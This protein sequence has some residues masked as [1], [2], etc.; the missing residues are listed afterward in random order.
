MFNKRI[1]LLT[2]TLAIVVISIYL[3]N[4]YKHK[5]KELTANESVSAKKYSPL[6]EN[7]KGEAVV[8]P[9]DDVVVNTYGTWKVVYTVGKEGIT[10][11]GG[12]V[13]HI[14]PYWGWSAP[15]NSNQDYPG[16]ITVSTSN[17]RVP[18]LYSGKD[19]RGTPYL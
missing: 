6:T 13:V 10:G 8:I 9:S 12:I 14:S 4:Q 11:G 2:C 15:Q 5:Q 18:P 17:D 1:I 16:Y 3:L 7:G 19:K